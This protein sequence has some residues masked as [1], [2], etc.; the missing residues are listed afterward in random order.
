MWKGLWLWLWNLLGLWI[1]VW[2][3]LLRKGKRVWGRDKIMW[4]GMF[5]EIGI[6]WVWKGIRV[7]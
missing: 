3:W 6:M 7:D 1:G 2:L 5:I 4:E